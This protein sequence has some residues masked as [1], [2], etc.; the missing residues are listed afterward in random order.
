MSDLSETLY[1]RTAPLLEAQRAAVA[2]YAGLLDAQRAALRSED[3]DLLG[4]VAGQAAGL[5]QGLAEVSRHLALLHA[6]LGETT[7]PR[8]A[9]VRSVFKALNVELDRIFAEIRQFTEVVQVRR[10]HLVR[11]L[12]EHDGAALGRPGNRFR[13]GHADSAFLDRSG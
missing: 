2:R 5:L 3:F 11:T 7:G 8:S 4:E 6:P 13:A 9:A 1:A 10:D 12:R